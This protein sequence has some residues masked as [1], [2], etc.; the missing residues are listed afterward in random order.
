MA[1][2]HYIH[3]VPMGRITEMTG[4]NF[5]TLTDIFHRLSRYFTPVMGAL[6]EEYRQ[7][8]VKHADETGWRNDGQNGYAWLFCTPDMSIFSFKDTR[9]ASV[10]KSIFGEKTLPGV[11]VVD[12]YNGYNKLPVQIQYCYAHLLRDVEKLEKDFPDE[13]EVKSFTGTLI[14]LIAEAIYLHTEAIPDE[15]YYRKAEKIKEQIIGVINNPAHHLGIRAI[16]DTFHDHEDRLYHLSDRQARPCRQQSGRER[17]APY[18]YSQEGKLRL[19]LRCRGS[20]QISA[21]VCNSY[22]Q[23]EKKRPIS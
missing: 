19:K 12:R 16:Q 6:K 5:G 3:G 23:Q 10:P 2:M 7:S 18:C 20:Y 1:V 22:P 11:L 14:P 4:I 8:P 15:E 13:K 21:H 17:P 9:A